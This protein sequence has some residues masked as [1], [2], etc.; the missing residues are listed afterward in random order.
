[1][2]T[3]MADWLTIP[4]ATPALPP[5]AISFA[6]GAAGGGDDPEDDDPEDDDPEDDD[7][8][9]D[10]LAD[11]S[12]EELRAELKKTRVSLSK[13]NG[14]SMKRRRALREKERELEEARKPKPKK[15]GDGEDDGPDLDTIRH[16]A[17]SEGEKAG[18]ARAKKAE[19]RA[20]LLSAG[21]NPERAAKAIGLLNLDE[22]DLDDDGLDGIDEAIED[23]RKTWP[24]LFA[25]PRK[26]REHVGGERG[27][28][29]GERRG[30][31]KTASEIA[32]ERL[33]RRA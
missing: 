30:K 10:D 29:D 23:L 4:D 16:E 28:D 17:K 9:D 3:R 15:K 12:E 13:V 22:L 1:M 20:S 11:L 2:F 18:I 14:Q 31:A 33:L 19:A 8:E 24:E 32:A 26:K 5:Y 25:K 21:V 7:P 27:G 6:K